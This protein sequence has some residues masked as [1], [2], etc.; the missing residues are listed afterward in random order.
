MEETLFPEYVKVVVVDDV[1]TLT[2]QVGARTF[3][4]V[5]EEAA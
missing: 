3:T 5:L 4:V 2:I 1:A